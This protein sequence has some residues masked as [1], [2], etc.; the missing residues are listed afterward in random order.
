MKMA[1][2]KPISV[3]CQESIN[4]V[5]MALEAVRVDRKF[6]PESSLYRAIRELKG[7]LRLEANNVP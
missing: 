4:L 5:A 2:L 1:D 7:R 6:G 3:S